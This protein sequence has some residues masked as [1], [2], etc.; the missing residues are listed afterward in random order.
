MVRSG[1]NSNSS[2]ILCMSSLPASIKRIGSKTTENKWRHH[3][4]HYESMGAF[5]SHGNQSFDPICPKTFRSLSPNSMMLHIK[6]DQDWQTGYR[7]IF[8]F[9]SVKF[10]SFKGKLLQNEWSDWAQ[11]RTQPSFYACSGYQQL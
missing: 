6:F 2:E 11:N 8:M 5:C 9:K 1:R 3:F 10:S 7:D 4:P